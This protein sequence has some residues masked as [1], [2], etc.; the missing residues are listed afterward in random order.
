MGSYP[1]SC[2]GAADPNYSITYVAGD[3][4]ITKATPTV[5]ATGQ[6]GQTTGPV[7][8]TVT[9]NGPT[10]AAYDRHGHRLGPERNLH[11]PITLV[12]RRRR[13]LQLVEN[14]A[15]DDQWSTRATRATRTTRRIPGL[16]WRTSLRR[17]LR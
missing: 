13:Q 5:T 11:L 8:I 2:S 4:V 6:A 17:L 3:I 9:V 7:T 14:A 15:E 16:P 10:G 1:D 12:S